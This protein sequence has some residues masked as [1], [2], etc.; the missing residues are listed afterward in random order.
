MIDSL[1]LL[2]VNLYVCYCYIELLKSQKKKRSVLSRNHW[3]WFQ[4]F[5]TLVP[6]LERNVN[7]H[8]KL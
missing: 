1:R 8:K 5:V 6:F 4:K 2:F 3:V 7:I